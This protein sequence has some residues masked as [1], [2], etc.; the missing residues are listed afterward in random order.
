MGVWVKQVMHIKEGTF[1]DEHWV[2]YV[3]NEVLGSTLKAKTTLYV[4]YLEFEL[5]INK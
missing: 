4:T 5:K 2:S 3:R 1:L